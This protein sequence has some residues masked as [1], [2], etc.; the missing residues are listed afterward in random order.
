MSDYDPRITPWAVKGLMFPQESLREQ[1]I[2]L[3]RFAVL[4]PSIYNT[5]PW[6][7]RVSPPQIGVLANTAQRFAACDPEGRHLNVSLGCA[8]ENLLIAAEHFGFS[9]DVRYFPDVDDVYPWVAAVTF[10]PNGSTAPHRQHLFDCIPARHTNHHRYQDR[11]VPAE[12]LRAL[13]SVVVEEGIVLH[14]IDDLP[15]QQ[16]LRA[17]L[18]RADAQLFTDANARQAILDAVLQG[19]LDVGWLASTLGRI[20]A[21]A[22]RLD[23]FASRHDEDMPF[24]APLVGMILSR[25]DDRVQQVRAGQAFERVHLAATY[26]GLSM[27]PINHALGV[28]SIRQAFVKALA[29]DLAPQ[30][31]FRLGFAD[32][33]PTHTPR[34]PLE[35]VLL[36]N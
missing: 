18:D 29:L 35:A 24:H 15:T 32:P 12:V 33:E 8:L 5:Q 13:Q 17:W 26:L 23:A 21:H 22:L 34:R 25:E 6:L 7:F 4:A 36:A 14:F 27:Q 28:P 20:A 19:T 11:P 9:H 16:R 3:L 2:F 1:L 30:M 10:A 31:L